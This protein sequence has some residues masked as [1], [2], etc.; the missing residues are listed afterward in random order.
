M[1]PVP[2]IPVIKAS[3][4]QRA[5]ASLVELNM[6]PDGQAMADLVG[7]VFQA[8]LQVNPVVTD[9]PPPERAAN[10]RLMEYFINSPSGQSTRTVTV[11]NLPAVIASTPLVFAGLTSPEVIREALEKQERADRAAQEA[12][13]NEAVA[14]LLRGQP[15]AE[16]FRQHAEELNA[17]ASRLADEATEQLG[18][19]LSDPLIITAIAE[20]TRRAENTARDVCAATIGFDLQPGAPELTNPQAA[21][22]FSVKVLGNPTVAKVA[23]MAGR[24]RGVALSARR[25][26]RVAAAVPRQSGRTQRL[27]DA[28]PGELAKLHPDAPP[29]IRAKGAAE[30]AEAGLVGRVPNRDRK[31][32]GPFV[33]AVDNSG[34]MRGEPEI[35]SK[36]IAIAIAQLAKAEGR[37]GVLFLF[38]SSGD[39]VVKAD[40]QDWQSVMD[41]AAT[42]IYG[43][44]DFAAALKTAMRF[45]HEL[46]PQSDLLFITDGVG[47][48]DPGT[49]AELAKFRRENDTRLYFVAV[50]TIVPHGLN[51]DLVV[52]TSDILQ[53]AQ[54]IAGSLGAGLEL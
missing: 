42:S 18:A 37:Q 32:R 3:P 20:N 17:L 38:S 15:D 44:T 45:L 12:R 1:K 27:Q 25:T 16:R 28:L 24:L 14:G 34:S 43:G 33:V 51:P 19:A 13:A 21:L 41:F 10:A 49:I 54:S 48:L 7:D 29:V 22:N 30:F 9:A 26:R 6:S 50:R 40:V 4:G 39:R 53:D 2:A 11:G 46:G 31:E 8:L 23:R 52:Y 5:I 47:Y 36:A 35:V